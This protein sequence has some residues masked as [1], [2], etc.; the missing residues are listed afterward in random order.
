MDGQQEDKLY[1]YGEDVKS[2]RYVSNPSR[3]SVPAD[4]YRE[5]LDP[6]SW[7]NGVYVRDF[8]MPMGGLRR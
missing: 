3:F 8:R 6:E 1:P 7:P 5:S 4:D 2:R